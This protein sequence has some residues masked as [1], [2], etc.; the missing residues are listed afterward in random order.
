MGIGGRVL[1]RTHHVE[2]LQPKQRLFLGLFLVG[3]HHLCHQ[4]LQR[5][6]GRPAQLL[7]GPGGIAQQRF[8]LRRAEVAWI[9]PHHHLVAAGPA[10][11]L[12]QP[13]T[14]PFDA[15]PA[16]FGGSELD[17]AAYALLYLA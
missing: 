17:E 3:G 2:A 4:L 8:H 13:F 5:G 11:L 16:Q 14:A 6:G 12:L 1:H 10:A 9:D 15:A 7:A